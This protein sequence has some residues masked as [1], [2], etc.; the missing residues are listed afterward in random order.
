MR[1]SLRSYGLQAGL[2]HYP[3]TQSDNE[4]CFSRWAPRSPQRRRGP[5]PP[6]RGGP[7]PTPC[8]TYGGPLCGTTP[9]PYSS[10]YTDLY[11][12]PYSIQIYI[13]LHTLYRSRSRSSPRVVVSVAPPAPPLSHS[14]AHVQA[15]IKTYCGHS[16]GL[17]SLL[18]HLFCCYNLFIYIKS[19]SF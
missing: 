12:P 18:N 11:Q 15:I 4:P 13:S 14:Q 9:A 2:P 7:S 19:F 5:P 17:L 3:I 1:C 6:P 10:L 16:C 8:P